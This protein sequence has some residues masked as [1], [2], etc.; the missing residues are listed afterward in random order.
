MWAVRPRTWIASCITPPCLVTHVRGAVRLGDDRRV[1][2]DP[3]AQQ[4]SGAGA[5]LELS[6]DAGEDQLAAARETRS[7]RRGRR[8]D[9]GGD[10][11]LH[12]PDA[13]AEEQVSLGRRLRTDRG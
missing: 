1:G 6:Y 5:S 2:A 8:G 3:R 11:R 9:H 12:V 13:G 7:L 10:S 4:V